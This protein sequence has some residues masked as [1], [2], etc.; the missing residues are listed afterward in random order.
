MD[1]ASSPQIDNGVFDR[2]SDGW[3]REDTFAALLKNVSNPWRIPYFQRM[4]SQELKMDPKGKRALDL[5]CGGGIL[6]E[7]FARMGFDVTGIDPSSSSLE[8]ARAH[9]VWVGL[10]IDYRM[11]YGDDLPFENETFEIVFCCDVLDH[12]H[13]WDEVIGEVARVLKRNGVLFFD[14]INRNI[15][16]KITFIKLAQEWRFTRFF[17]P[18]LHTWEIFITPEELKASLERHG[19][20]HMEINGTKPANPIQ[21][22]KTMRQYK[23]GKISP[24]E[25]GKRTGAQEGS[26]TDGLYMGYAVKL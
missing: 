18:H 4:L 19:L 25:L 7:E 6:A 9:A 8:A 2:L 24:A 14:T 16:S 5:G 20:Q 1:S 10:N 11:A 15:F 26:N 13:N 21:M 3:W 17:P 23:K 22:F 12:I